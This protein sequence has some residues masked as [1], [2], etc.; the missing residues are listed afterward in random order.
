MT[1]SK[2]DSISLAE[3]LSQSIGRKVTHAEIRVLAN[4]NG[5]DLSQLTEENAS[6]YVERFKVILEGKNTQNALGNGNTASSVNEVD[7]HVN[8]GAESQSANSMSISNAEYNKMD[9]AA[10]DAISNMDEVGDRYRS[11]SQT[12]TEG[13]DA[14]S[15]IHEEVAGTVSG[16]LRAVTRIKAEADEYERILL[17]HASAQRNHVTDY[18][19]RLFTKGQALTSESTDNRIKKQAQE[20]Q[21]FTN[22]AQSLLGKLKR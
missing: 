18:T 2:T 15:L 11:N 7:S 8:P 6:S 19:Q 3:Q 1:R 14:E 5:V 4:K 22:Y 21:E 13:M 12:F 9:I 16:R 10:T 17:E 20:S